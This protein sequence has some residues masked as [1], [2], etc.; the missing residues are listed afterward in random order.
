MN[1]T[2]PTRGHRTATAKASCPACGS[3]KK[4]KNIPTFTVTNEPQDPLSPIHIQPKPEEFVTYKEICELMNEHNPDLLRFVETFTNGEVPER[5]PKQQ[6]HVYTGGM[7]MHQIAQSCGYYAKI[8]KSV[9]RN[10][11]NTYFSDSVILDP[12]AGE[13][14][15]AK[16]LREEGIPVY[17]TDDKSWKTD[18]NPDV[19]TLDC[20]ESLHKYGSEATVLVISWPPYNSPIA[21]QLLAERDAHFPNLE[22]LYIGEGSRGCTGDEDFHEMLDN[23]YVDHEIGYRVDYQTSPG[24]HDNIVSVLPGFVDG[25]QLDD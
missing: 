15:L 17:A 6:P 11:K 21:A 8:T 22:V 10:L 24:L 3:K 18:M 1:C 4:K 16:A 19:E 12:L 23:R 20:I 5:Y 7:H 14:W 25:S 2:A 9:A 13:G